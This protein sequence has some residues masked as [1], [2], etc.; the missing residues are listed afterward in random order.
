MRLAKKSPN[1]KALIIASPLL[2]ALFFLVQQADAYDPTRFPGKGSKQA[3]LDAGSLTNSGNS[4][5]DQG[6]HKEAIEKYK[7][8]IEIYPYAACTFSNAGNSFQ[9]LGQYATAVKYYKKATE[10]APDYFKAVYNIGNSFWKL[11]NFSEAEKAFK[12]S[13]VLN[14][15]DID[16][17]INLGELYLDMKRPTDAKKILLEAQNLPDSK[18]TENKVMLD[19]DLKRVN[20]EL[21]LRGEK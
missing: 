7:R 6:K 13:I 8:S 9:D 2:V 10:L 3:W 12:R 17:R 14:P 21:S 18:L 4:L 15:N 20:K 11:K 16:P 19:G 5:A 1:H